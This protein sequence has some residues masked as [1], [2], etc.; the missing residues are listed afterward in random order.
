VRVAVDGRVLR[1][2]V[3]HRR[4]VARYLRCLLEG[5][6]ALA[7]GDEYEVLVAGGAD[8]DPFDAPGV[9]VVRRRAPGRLV[10]G[11]GVLAGRPRLDRLVGGCDVAWVPAPAPVA[12]SR[13]VPVV[14]T[15]HDLSFDRPQDFSRYDRV[16][17]RLARPGRLARRATAV[18]CVST[19][20]REAALARWRLDPGRLR[21]VPSGPGRP[22]GPAGGLP[23]GLPDRFVLA[24]GA[25]EPRKLPGVLAEAHRRAAARGLEAGLVFAGEGPLAGELERSGAT[26]LGH[27][28]DPVL[29]ALYARSLA[30]VCASRDEGFGFTPLEALARGTPAL[31]AD[32]PV[33]AETLADGALRVPPGDADALADALLRLEREPELRERLVAAGREA[34]GRL[35]WERAA[36]ATRAVLAEAAA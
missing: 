22:P 17:H 4:G 18:M 30:L 13:E 19:P 26:V 9:H 14:L 29:E 24:V 11:A 33:F 7:P 20:V 36:R 8:P 12:V 34:V 25:L 6:A 1:P 23:P 5:L 32:L 28:P 15:L 31:V 10:F 35:S 16:W 21:V 27:V 3:V 2:Q